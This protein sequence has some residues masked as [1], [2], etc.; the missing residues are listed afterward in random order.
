MYDWVLGLAEKPMGSFY[1]VLLAFAESSFFPI[2]P[3]V[4]L[5]ALCLGAR[6]K[7]FKF[8]LYCSSGSILGG[9][10]GY[11]IGHYLWWSSGEFSALAHFFF[12]YIPGFDHEKFSSIRELYNSYNFWIVFTAGFT[13]I[14]YKIITITA[15]CFNINFFIFSILRLPSL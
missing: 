4:L 12:E 8:A 1:L 7:C 10:F 14:P 3:D 13:P 15:G 6:K 5:M 11:G 2:P 9:I